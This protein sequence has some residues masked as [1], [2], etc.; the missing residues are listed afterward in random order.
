MTNI[1]IIIPKN[2]IEAFGKKWKVKELAIFGS[3]LRDD[4]NTLTSDIDVLITFLPNDNWGWEI[5]EMKEELE[6][7][8]KHKVDLIEKSA[9]EKDS[10]PIRRQEILKNYKVVYEQAA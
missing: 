8:F 5:V 9:V 4:F 7:I 3:V 6:Q 10:N 2:Q 1:K